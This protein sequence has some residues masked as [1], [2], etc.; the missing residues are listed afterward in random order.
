M[1]ILCLRHFL[2][3][4]HPSFDKRYRYRLHRDMTQFCLMPVVNH[5]YIYISKGSGPKIDPCA[6]PQ[7]ISP[8]S[9]KTSFGVTKK[10]LFERYDWN[11]LMT[12]S[13]KPIHSIFCESTVW[14]NL[15][16]AFCRSTRIIPVWNS[17]WIRLIIKSVKL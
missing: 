4:Q 14:S 6:R 15:L 3:F 17:L 9:E 16:N 11:S 12:V 10:S 5:L 7:F 8:A 2:V 1:K 13:L